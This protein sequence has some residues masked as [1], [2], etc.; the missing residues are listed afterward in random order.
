[1]AA[2]DVTSPRTFGSQE[3]I[4]DERWGCDGVS[5]ILDYEHRRGKG[6]GD[7]SIYMQAIRIR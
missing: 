3:G 4:G 2:C 5:V 1:M 7:I 6:R